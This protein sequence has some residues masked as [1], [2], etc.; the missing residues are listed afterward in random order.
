VLT[1]DPA[2]LPAD[3]AFKGYEETLVQDVVIHTDNVLYRKEKYYSP[4]CTPRR[5]PST[6][7]G[8]AA[9][10]GTTWTIRRRGSMARTRIVMWCVI[11]C[12][13]PTSRRPTRTG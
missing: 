5:P 1:V 10:H 2:Q 9:A 13:R 11:R 3:A 7:P 4:N 8:C 12:I 6:R